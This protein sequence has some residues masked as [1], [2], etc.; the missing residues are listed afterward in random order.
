MTTSITVKTH[1]WPVQVRT[2]QVH[3]HRKDEH[4]WSN[5]FSHKCEVVPPHSERLFSVYE[6]VT[7]TFSEMPKPEDKPKPEV[8]GGIEISGF[9]ETAKAE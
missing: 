2:E 3:E 9:D 7:V 4:N 1:D 6:G 5:S 8:V